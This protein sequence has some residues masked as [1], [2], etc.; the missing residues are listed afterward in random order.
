MM[1]ASNDD[2]DTDAVVIIGEIGGPA[3]AEAALWCKANMK[4]PIRQA[5]G[6]CWGDRIFRADTDK[7][8][9]PL[10]IN[11]LQRRGVTT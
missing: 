5:H 1:R 11:A 10:K 9:I 8:N 3:E 2:S 4:K 7:G 6:P